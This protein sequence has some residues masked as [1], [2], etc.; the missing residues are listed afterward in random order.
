MFKIPLELSL[1][2]VLSDLR[3]SEP[4]ALQRNAMYETWHACYNAVREVSD[5]LA[6]G[7]VNTSR[8]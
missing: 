6:V 7:Y 4:P 2:I 5:D 8:F 1:V 3:R